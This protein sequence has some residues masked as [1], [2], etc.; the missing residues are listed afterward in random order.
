[1]SARH[2]PWAGVAR[3]FGLAGE[4]RPLVGERTA[5]AVLVGAGDRPVAVLKLHPA[6]DGP[7]IDLETAALAHLAQQPDLNRHVPQVLRTADGA[8]VIE[9]STGDGVRLARALSWVPG[10][11]WRSADATPD[12]LA[13][14]GRVVARVDL[15][16]AGFD[17]PHAGRS[18]PWNL[19]EAGT[20]LTLV[21]NVP[22]PDRRQAARV[23]LQHFVDQVAPR[24]AD[25]DRQ[26]IHNDANPANIVLDED[27][28]PPGPGLIDFGDLCRAPRICGLAVACA[29]VI[30]GDPGAPSGLA[31][32]GSSTPDTSVPEF[33]AP[34]DP[35]RVVGPLV[36]GY[37]ELAPLTGVELELLPDLVRT[38]LAL[39][40]V[41]AGWQHARDPA[42]AYLLSSQDAVAPAVDRLAARARLPHSRLEPARLRRELGLE[43]WPGAAAVRDHLGE[44][45]PR[46]VL[47]R[48]LAEIG[49]EVMDW[50]MPDPPAVTVRERHV[51]IGRYLED[52][53]VYR[54][55]AYRTPTGERR[56]IHLGVDLFVPAG[57]P[58]HAPL[59]GV[60][61]A[62]GDN[63]APLDYGPVIILRHRTGDG[64]EFFTLYG[65]LARTSL[66]GL[67]VGD[68]VAAG[69]VFATVGT[70]QENG[71]WEPHLHLQVLTDLL[72]MG[73]DVPGV[74]T[75]GDL[76]LWA[77]LCPDPNLIL[78]VPESLDAR[79]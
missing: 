51:L 34:E 10:R 30:A 4:V 15:A 76:D 24:L 11:T 45:T 75:R 14:L 70:P 52:R 31:A 35:W 19:V 36:A 1:M 21:D 78:R 6:G 64:T 71:G 65:H 20:A 79:S 77:E 18:L 74:G 16:L 62:L 27:G 57:H 46:P 43:A 55:E 66:A 8:S 69:Q 2:L 22:D 13:G 47:G 68:R 17:H 33:S 59:D 56:T 37:H 26:V 28:D 5:N 9:V 3:R 50:S 38:R 72:G 67:A 60:V 29:Y 12:Q 53:T 39:S 63:T 58:L 32:S 42:N 23:V 44:V 49:R 41:M 40:V 54:T 48:P 73:L 25:L 7:Q 61:E